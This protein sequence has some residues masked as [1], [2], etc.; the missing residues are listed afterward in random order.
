MTK[1]R[2]FCAT[3]LA[4]GL[5]AGAAG[6]QTAPQRKADN[7]TS[8]TE[9]V[10][11][12]TR[13]DQKVLDVPYNI[14]AV[15]G[16]T[17]QDDHIQNSAELLRS[18]PGVA[19]VDRGPRNQGTATNIQM[20]GINVDSSAVGDYWL[21]TVAPVSTYVNDTPLFANFALIDLARV[22]VLRGPQ[23]TLY[24]S[25][26]LG[27]TVR[28]ISNP[29]QFGRF[30]GNVALTTTQTNGSGGVG[31]EG[32]GVMNI[33][34]GDKL[35]IRLNVVDQDY[36]GITDYVNLYK[37]GANGIPV[38][39]NGIFSSTASY[40]RK[41]DADTTRIQ[42]DRVAIRFDPTNNTDF[43]L[44]YAHQHDNVGGRRQ[45]T[46]GDNGYGV[47]YGSYQNGAVLL[48]PSKRNVDLVALEGVV[49]F[50]F[51]TLTS[52]TSY[53]DHTGS[54]TTDN[55]GFYAN[56]TL[57]HNYYYNYPRPAAPAYRTYGDQGLIEE[58]RLVSK[59]G[60]RFDWVV[61]V[62]A[63]RDRNDQKQDDYVLGFKQYIN[64]YF[65]LPAD[66]NLVA[67][68]DHQFLYRAHETV[69]DIA[70]YGELTWHVTDRLQLTGGL[71]HFRTDQATNLL[72]DFPAFT[73]VSSPDA[74]PT[75]K[76]D[77]EKTLFKFN[78]SY[79]I[80]DNSL[81]YA[82]VSQ[83]YRRGGVNEVA[84][85]GRWA[86]DPRWRTYAP[87][88]V[89]NYEVGVKGLVHGVTFNAAAYYVDWSKIQLN[90][91]SDLYGF[92]VVANGKTARSA[93]FEG[94]I[95]GYL[96]PRLHYDIGYTYTNASLT[97][98]FISPTGVLLAGKGEMLPGTPEHAVTVAGDYTVP[99]DGGAKL[100]FRLN[101]YYQSM[102]RNA[103]GHPST[104]AAD[105]FDANLPPF[106]LWNTTM[107]WSLDRVD[108]SLF[109]KNI[110]NADGVTG[111]FTQAYE[112]TNP[113]F[114][115]VGDPTA[116][117][118]YGNDAKKFITLPRT[119]GLAVNYRW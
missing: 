88:T 77:S 80:T 96:A 94:Q 5:V 20:R 14:T 113:G 37:L 84:T 70:G 118:F 43:T 66:S 67:S 49:D 44:S 12:A 86:E 63:E 24:G 13:R 2:L 9:V 81:A 111:E 95:A 106:S 6:A 97:S 62:F 101:G 35:A 7:P 15:S 25:G 51:A 16:R 74:P 56:D 11:T 57:F 119:V 28:Y 41:K 4:G 55:T 64:A 10:V 68:S 73:A 32:D 30:S 26:S 75:I 76:Q 21:P 107:T 29:P 112:G 105:L 18:V 71:R 34:L 117:N 33:P 31:W 85:T 1:L 79:K 87:D 23:G 109:V 3:A 59:A 8:L 61:G 58:V 78:G 114:P 65:G 27:G 40:Y 17:I 45:E 83:G 46:F 38:A 82:T 50:G 115:T 104:V 93:G 102:T 42:Y 22:E 98:N 47:P 53:F 39:P 91:F 72:I 48:E 89:V 92:Y 54:S 100:I 103:L 110:F 52:S 60:K 36:P 108:V 99:L 69:N 90:T 116:A 19:L